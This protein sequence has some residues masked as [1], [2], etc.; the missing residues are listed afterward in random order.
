VSL[1]FGFGQQT[2]AKDPLES[3]ARSP[4][5]AS[6]WII[7]LV[8]FLFSIAVGMIAVVTGIGGAVIFVPIVGSLFPINLDFIRGAGLMVALAGAL[9][10]SPS[11]LKSGLADLR[12]ALPM[13]L[14]SS[15][16]AIFGALIGLRLP[17]H[18]IQTALG[19]TMISIVILMTKTSKSEF[20]AVNSSDKLAE[21]LGISGVYHEESTGKD[22]PWYIHRSGL[23]LFLFVFIGFVAGMFGL[24]AGWAN[25]PLLNLVLGAPLKISIG[26]S[27]FILS[28]TDTTAAWVYINAG[29]VL[30]LITVPSIMGMILG[31]YMGVRLL[32]KG[33]PAKIKW[34]VIILLLTAGLISLTKGIHSWR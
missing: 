30:P 9:Y 4:D 32:K 22:V 21:Y 18:V 19:L 2:F 16:S 17:T 31:T 3:I 1:V 14:I 6:W 27:K 26:T 15:T 13:A 12:L 11:L 33:S 29:A 28:I 7:P 10:A 20:P 34:F 5:T 25:V 24:G 8:L 23:G